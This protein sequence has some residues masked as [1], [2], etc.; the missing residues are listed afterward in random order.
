VRIYHSFTDPSGGSSD[1]FTLAVGHVSGIEKRGVLDGFWERRP[2]FSP[3]AVCEEFATILK[4]YRVTTVTGDKYAAAWVAERFQRH[5]IRYIHSERTKSEIYADFVALVNSGRV[6]M[7]WNKR[8]RTQFESLE[9]RTSRS[10]RDVIDHP[11]GSHDDI[12][13]AVAGVLTLALRVPKRGYARPECIF[14]AG[15]RKWHRLS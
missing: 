3:D 1:A 4:E 2:P 10:G 11:A 5:G 9:R 6:R 13:N 7:P 14:P 8:L 15:V 12:C